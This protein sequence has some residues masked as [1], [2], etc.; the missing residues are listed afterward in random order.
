[1]MRVI[2]FIYMVISVVAGS[3]NVAAAQTMS[4]YVAYPPFVT[5]SVPPNILLNLDF[6]GSMQWP[7]Y[8]SCEDY[9]CNNLYEQYDPAKDYDGYFKKDKYYQYLTDKFYEN[10]GCTDTD[11]IGSPN[12][13]SGNL[14]NWAAMSRVDVMRKALIGGKA[15]SNLCAISTLYGEGSDWTVYD[16]NLKCSFKI[17]TPSG[18]SHR[19]S[20]STYGVAS[21]QCTPDTVYSDDFNDAV[22]DS[23]WAVADIGGQSPAVGSTVTESGGNLTVN[24]NGQNIW[25][26]SDNFTYVYQAVS[27]DFDIRLRIITPP[28]AISGQTFAKAGLMVRASTAA[29]SRHVMVNATHASGLQ[30]ARRSSDGGST[31]TFANY[32]SMSYPVWIRLVRSGNTFYA[33]YSSD[34]TNWTYRASTSVTMPDSVLVGMNTAS[35]DANTHDSGIYDEFVYCQSSGCTV[36]TVSNANLRV[37]VPGG[38]RTGG[39]ILDVADRDGDCTYDTDAAR[40]GLMIFSGS[41]YGCMET[42]VEEADLSSLIDHIQNTPPSG[43]TPTIYAMEEAWDYFIQDNKFNNCDNSVYV[44][45][46]GTTKDPWYENT[47]P[48]PCRKSFILTLS[49]GEWNTGGDPIQDV[50]NSHIDDIRT[51]ITGKQF[52]IHYTIFAAFGATANYGRTAMQQIAMYGAFDDTDNNTWPYDRTAYPSPNS[53]DISNLLPQSPCDPSTQWND[54]CREWDENADGIPDTYFDAASGSELALKLR[55]AIQG[56]T[57]NSSSGTA[58][59]VLA[60]SGAGEGA[61]YQAYFYQRKTEGA[62]QRKWLGYLHA[63]FVDQWGNLREDTNSDAGL[64][65]TDDY[66]IKMRFDKNLGTLVDKYADSDGDGQPDSPNSPVAT[67]SLDDVKTI[68]DGGKQLWQTLPANRKILTTVNGYDFT[69]LSPDT[70]KGTFYDANAGTLQPYLRAADNDNDTEAKNIINWIRG[71]DLTGVTDTGHANGYRQRGITIG[72]T[73]NVWKLGDI[74]YSTP[75]VVGLPMENYDML[76]NN[77]SYLDFRMHY[78]DRREVVYV[79]A[80]DGML[81]AFNAGFYDEETRQY[82]TKLD[83]NGAC[84][85]GG[86]ALGSELWAFIPRGLLPHLKWLTDTDYDHIYYVD[87]KPKV[88]DVKIFTPDTTHINGWGTILIGG[89]RYGG[90]DITWTSGGSTYQATHE[91]FAL[92]ITDPD[93]PSLLWTFSDASL[94]IGMSYPAI[95]KVCDQDRNNCKWF[96]VFGSGAT[97]YDINSNLTAYQPGNIFVLDISSGTNGLIKTWTAG[98]NYWKLPTAS[99]D[100]NST[101]TYMSPTI[102]VDVDLDFDT[103]V[104]YIGEN[105]MSGGNWKSQILRITTDSG[106][107]NDPSKWT[108][109]VLI[110]TSDNVNQITSAVSAAMDD[111]AN[112]WVFLGTGR[113]LG[114]DDKNLTD[115]GAFYAVKDP[116]WAGTC[117]S[118]YT[119]SDLLNMDSAVVKTDG[120]VSGVSGSCTTVTVS[121]WSE[122]KQAIKQ[123]QGWVINLLNVAETTAFDTG[124]TIKHAGERV[125]SKP[126]VLGGLVTWTT[127]LP[128]GDVCSYGGESNIYS[129]YYETGT[130]FKKYVFKAQKSNPPA[131]KVVARVTKFGEGMPS[132]VSALVTASGSTKGFAQQSTGAIIELES[133]TP[134][135]LKTEIMGWKDE[136]LP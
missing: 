130:A 78:I 66:I 47:Q 91:Y 126:L 43:S 25:S 18:L 49:D 14:L 50:R 45:G 103:D 97:D 19:L 11:G 30:F 80:N 104:I 113:F 135:S 83:T 31:G 76:Y 115:T 64:S 2:L 107:E 87:L 112:L 109:S 51:D 132:T 35:Y 13:I 123:C 71:D 10:S 54:L 74:V 33:Y 37:D 125:L 60:T 95:S 98:T 89:F 67:V 39:V 28:G 129:V 88:S 42:G 46:T 101:Q 114:S 128:A 99:Y 59:S 6:S 72:T 106:Q 9:T 118:E 84:T 40:F 26:S 27:G 20:I 111:R 93:N 110:N 53:K 17:D 96:A 81:H 102:N 63:L 70:N 119:V 56:I 65:L 41:Y 73:T 69:G 133:L 79:G 120:S 24:T 100:N 7:A 116:C 61:V 38:K 4:D 77:A 82:C 44:T 3:I 131:S 34:G 127:Y 94:G 75:T 105:Y 21:S 52:L 55:N 1:M 36:G 108:T 58:V 8:L 124:E 48:V 23:K 122:L 86:A 90:K 5:S 134:F 57:K 62:A 32:V 121:T 85:T 29:D 117:S 136:E 22:F 16:S 68:W 15:A 92:D 12:C